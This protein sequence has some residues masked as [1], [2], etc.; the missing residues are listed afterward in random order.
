M[1]IDSLVSSKEQKSEDI[2]LQ[3]PHLSDKSHSNRPPIKLLTNKTKTKTKPRKIMD[4]NLLYPCNGTYQKTNGTTCG[5][6][7]IMIGRCFEFQYIK[8]GF[9]LTNQS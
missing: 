7:E 5:L 3:A 8:L 1:N 6:K 2:H 9:F 4:K